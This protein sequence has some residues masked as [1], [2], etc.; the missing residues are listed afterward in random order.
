MKILNWIKKEWNKPRPY[1]PTRQEEAIL[2]LAEYL[3]DPNRDNYK[4]VKHIGN[5]LGIELSIKENKN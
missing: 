2:K 3:E 5:I 4:I 1:K